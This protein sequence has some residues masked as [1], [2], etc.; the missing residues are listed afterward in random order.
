MKRE[1]L[2]FE[3]AYIPYET[4]KRISEELEHIG[5]HS[6]FVLRKSLHPDDKDLYVVIA[7]KKNSY[8]LYYSFWSCYNDATITLN[9]GHYGYDDCDKC[10]DDALEY[11]SEW[12]TKMNKT[13]EN[14]KK[15]DAMCKGI[16][17]KFEVLE[18]NAGD[19]YLAVFAENGYV[20]YMK[21]GYEHHK[22]FILDDL[23]DMLDGFT[24]TVH[25]GEVDFVTSPEYTYSNLTDCEETSIIADNNGFYPLKCGSS[26]CREFG[27]KRE[28]IEHEIK[29]YRL[30]VTWEASGFIEV[31]ACS[32]EDAMQ[33]VKENPD[34]YSLP[35][36]SD[37]V[38]GSFRLAT[39]DVDEMREICDF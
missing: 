37:Y 27:I 36:E 1:N 7:A 11:V 17:R 32:L 22:Y 35:C 9:H 10:L 6:T 18:G 15:I 26:A 20:D 33:K 13:M 38:D 28:E 3:Y 21:Q 14:I 2:T 12:R 29:K 25:E 5:Y 8:A 31:E 30:A 39:E 24:P 34:E 23:N 16:K 19:L 4:R